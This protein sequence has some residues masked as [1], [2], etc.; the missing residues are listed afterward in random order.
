MFSWS[1]L[2][3]LGLL[4]C[5]VTYLGPVDI[6]TCNRSLKEN[7]HCKGWGR[8]VRRGTGPERLLSQDPVPRLPEEPP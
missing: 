8:P 1:L 6:G 5:E 4:P 3:P 7:P 2:S